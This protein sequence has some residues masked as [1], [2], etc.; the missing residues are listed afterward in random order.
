MDR[1]QNKPN[2]SVKEE[3]V[4]NI[5]KCLFKSEMGNFWLDE[6]VMK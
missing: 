4:T 6:A 2:S 5:L 1:V 3:F